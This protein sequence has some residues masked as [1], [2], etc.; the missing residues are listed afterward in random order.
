MQPW[1][2]FVYVCWAGGEGVC[3]ANVTS[4]DLIQLCCLINS[5]STC[6]Y[7]VVVVNLDVTYIINQ[8]L[9]IYRVCTQCNKQGDRWI[10]KTDLYSADIITK[11]QR[12][13]K[14][15]KAIDGVMK[16]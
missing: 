7:I 5:F 12:C 14:C 3:T 8:S 2:V 16:S 6:I 10:N 1:C 9:S 11:L 13:K 15:P 4:G